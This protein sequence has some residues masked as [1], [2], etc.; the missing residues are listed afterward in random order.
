MREKSEVRTEQL[1]NLPD[2]VRGIYQRAFLG[3]SRVSVIKAKCLE[4]TCNMRKEI[5][6]C[7]VYTCPLY[8]VRPYQISEEDETENEAE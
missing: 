1:K 6:L 2:S 8:E 7:E 5:T 4:C 3:K